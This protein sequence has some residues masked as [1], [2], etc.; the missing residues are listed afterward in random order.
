MHIENSSHHI[1]QAQTQKWIQSV[2]I[3]NNFC[4]FAGQV[5]IKNSIRYIVLSDTTTK[6]VMQTL[7]AE[8]SYLDE[9]A[10]IETTLI[11]FEHNYT[12]FNT[13]LNLV[14]KAERLLNKANYEGVYQLASFHPDYCFAGED[15]SDAAN[16]TNRSPYPMLHL[17]REESITQALAHFA[18]P[19]R[20]PENNIN[21]ARKI[22]VQQ[23]L[24]LRAACFDVK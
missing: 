9:H 20:I 8:C 22:G 1:I 6:G 11:I 14:S 18:H 23:M 19:E 12:Q 10:A 15:D 2:V 4:P 17:L 3:A 16:Y 21:T 5:F 13:Y 7:L 24:L